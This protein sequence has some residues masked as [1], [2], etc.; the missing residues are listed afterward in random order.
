MHEVLMPLGL[1]GFN[2]DE[3][4]RYASLFIEEMEAKWMCGEPYQNAIT[5]MN[6]VRR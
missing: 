3:K 5:L 6:Y 1:P 2:G 4:E